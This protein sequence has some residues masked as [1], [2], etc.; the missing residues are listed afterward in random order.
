M[1]SRSESGADM[2][3]AMSSLSVT[4]VKSTM[5]LP[6]VHG[7]SSSATQSLSDVKRVPLFEMVA[8]PE[9]SELWNL[10]CTVTCAALGGNLVGCFF[11]GGGLSIISSAAASSVEGAAAGP[12][13]SAF[14]G[15]GAPLFDFAA[16]GPFSRGARSQMGRYLLYSPSPT[17]TGRYPSPGA[18]RCSILSRGPGRSS[19]STPGWSVSAGVTSPSVKLQ[20]G[21]KGNR[22]H[23]AADLPALP[24]ART[25]TLRCGT[26]IATHKTSPSCQSAFGAASGGDFFS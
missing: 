4:S 23:S 18:L 11:S 6:V 25:F 22:T 20:P 26:S 10:R 2:P 7:S 13:S 17:T 14:G 9:T 8:R 12:A 16:L 5:C 21:G 19:I 1:E 24:T 15:G 3:N